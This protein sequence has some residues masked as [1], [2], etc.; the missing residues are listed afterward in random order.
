MIKI[1]YIVILVCTLGCFLVTAQNAIPSWK[2]A[3]FK[4]IGSN[5][6]TFKTTEYAHVFS[7]SKHNIVRLASELE[8]LTGI[9][10]SLEIGKPLKLKFNE[11]VKVLIGVFKD[12]NSNIKENKNA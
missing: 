3:S 7:A 8:G 6:E 1:R 2:A 10:L 4:I 12:K 5:Y 9:K 11:P